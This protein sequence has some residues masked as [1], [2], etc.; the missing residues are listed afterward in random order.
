MS[1][2]RRKVVI[3]QHRLLHYRVELFE[4]LKERCEAAGIELCLVH[5]DATDSERKKNDT[6]HLSWARMVA[7]R[8][9]RI[10]SKDI[11]WQ[12]FPREYRDADLVILMQENRLLS[13]Y[14]HLLSRKFSDRKIAYWGHGVN[15]QSTSSTGLRERWKKLWLDKVDWWFAYTSITQGILLKSGYMD[16]CITVLNN[17]IDNGSFQSDLNSVSCADI[18]D[19]RNSMG[20]AVDDPVGLF[21]GSLYPE[22]RP[23]L[24]LDAADLV[25]KELPGFHLIVI[26]DGPSASLISKAS[27][28]RPWIHWVGAK[29]GKDK[30][31]YFKLGKVILNPG[32]VGLHVLDSFCSGVPMVTTHDALHSPEVAYLKPGQNGMVVSS[33]AEEYAS[34]IIEI[35][36]DSTLYSVLSAGAL[37]SSREYTL[38]N[39]VDRFYGGIVGCLRD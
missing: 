13:N 8:Y 33:D 6:G 22:K 35:F 1:D 38:D 16:D 36:R 15:F 14:L 31:K 2:F 27:A 19:L 30:A 28:S 10:A 29:R 11:L 3:L 32:L 18:R 21:C 7:N 4:K 12:P 37:E 23:E 17:A 20:I 5:G 25:K 24:L 26:G 34:T 9:F 39:M